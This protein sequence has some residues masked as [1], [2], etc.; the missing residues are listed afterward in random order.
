MVKVFII[1]GGSG[2]VAV[3]HR[4]IKF[5][6]IQI[7]GVADLDAEAPALKLA[8]DADLPVFLEDPL[9][10]LQNLVVDLVFDLSGN[11][12]VGKKLLDL[13]GD[14]FDVATGE[15]T[16]ALWKIIVELENKEKR[17]KNELGKHQVLLEIG[18]MLSRSETPDQIFEAIVS[19]VIRISKMP[20]ASLSVYNKEKQQLF[21]VA[22]KGFSSEFY[23][24]AI[25]SVRPGGL[26]EHIL[27]NKMPILVPDIADYPAFNNPTIMKEG[28]Q[29]LIAIPLIGD[30]GPV[31]I[32]YCDDFEARS[33][34]DRL[35]DH[36][37]MLSTQ[38]VIAIQKQQTFERIKELSIR[39]PLTSLYNRRYFN[40]I[41]VSEIDRA[42][43][44]NRPLSVMLID[45]DHF[46][47]VNDNYGHPVGDQVLEGLA[48]CFESIVRPYDVLAR[49]GGEEFI[50]LMPETGETEAAASAERLRLAARESALLPEDASLSCS[51]GVCTFKKAKGAE[52]TAK[53][54]LHYADEA[55][56]RAKREGRDRVCFYRL[57]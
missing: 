50:I 18:L 38:A 45:I 57:T 44:L 1:G 24:N 11:P 37:Q 53:Q 34:P 4:L 36:L 19:G 14:D 35:S 46:K 21:L 43:R 51:I 39:D 5:N 22:T 48:H 49:F 3:L 27:S 28:I 10:I 47:Q 12:E 56:Y 9:F 8:R 6:W 25:Y 31:G 2:G 20:A 52:L 40:K 30:K 13:A 26:T 42:S 41:M 16:K 7:I 32:L 15:V 23:Q 55:L 17:I 33:F 54:F 29:S